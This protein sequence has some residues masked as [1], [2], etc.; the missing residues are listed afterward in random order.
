M[1]RDDLPALNRYRKIF[2]GTIFG[3]II[4]LPI[5][6]TS[7][8]SLEACKLKKWNNNKSTSLFAFLIVSS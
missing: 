5:Y 8:L 6:E 3:H 7:I 1:Q 2:K 4:S